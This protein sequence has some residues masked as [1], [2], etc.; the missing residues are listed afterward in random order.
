M[1]L[2][3][4]ADMEEERGVVNANADISIVIYRRRSAEILQTL[5]CMVYIPPISWFSPSS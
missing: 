4:G 5:G 2:R 3:A 1:R